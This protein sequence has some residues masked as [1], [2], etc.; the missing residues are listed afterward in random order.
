MAERPLGEDELTGIFERTAVASNRRLARAMAAEILASAESNR[1]EFARRMSKQVTRMTGP[2]LLDILRDDE[3]RDLVVMSAEGRTWPDPASIVS[4]GHGVRGSLHD[5]ELAGA[6]ASE[7]TMDEER[8]VPRTKATG[9][10]VRQ[11][12]KDMVAVAVQSQI[13]LGYRPMALLGMIDDLGG[14]EAARRIVGSEHPSKTFVTLWENNRLEY[15]V[16]FLVLDA[17]Y[18]GLFG[19]EVMERAAY[20]LRE[21]GA[22]PPNH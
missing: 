19:P 9:D 13:V 18:E 12:H 4:E 20:R 22:N 14:V 5:P 3:L 11:F 7:G 16:E 1:S 2:L 15:S 10:L 21:H 6:A 8:T 17:A